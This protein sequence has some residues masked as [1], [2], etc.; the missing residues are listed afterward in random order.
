MNT[1]TD[2]QPTGQMVIDALGYNLQ[3]ETNTYWVAGE[4]LPLPIEQLKSR[5]D[6]VLSREHLQDLDIE[7][8]LGI[9]SWIQRQKVVVPQ[10]HVPDFITDAM[11]PLVWRAMTGLLKTDIES[12]VA[13]EAVGRIYCFDVTP[14]RARDPRVLAMMPREPKLD[15]AWNAYYEGMRHWIRRLAGLPAPPLPKPETPSPGKRITYH[16]FG[17]LMKQKAPSLPRHLSRQEIACHI[18][19][20]ALQRFVALSPGILTTGEFTYV[21][22][23]LVRA[24]NAASFVQ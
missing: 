21:V 16:F 19:Q 7:H 13:A 17:G 2:S 11:A 9:L 6:E 20:G 12:I 24:M 10:R 18:F 22:I 8:P 15:L 23:E 5:G 3:T 1:R 14:R 4:N